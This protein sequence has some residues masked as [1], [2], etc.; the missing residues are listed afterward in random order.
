[1][2]TGDDELSLT[3]YLDSLSNW[4]ANLV[5]KGDLKT[6]SPLLPNLEQ[7]T[8][9][10]DLNLSISG[11]PI[12]PILDGPIKVQEGAISFVVGDQVVGATAIRIDSTFQNGNL[13]ITSIEGQFGQGEIDGSGNITKI[14]NPNERKL[15]GELRFTDASIAPTDN[16]AIYFDAVFEINKQGLEPLSI[17]GETNIT[18]AFYESKTNL[19]KILI[20]FTRFIA[21]IGKPPSVPQRRR[22]QEAIALDILIIAEDSLIVETNVMQGELRGKFRIYDMLAT[23]RVAGSI[24]VIDGVFGFQSSEFD[25]LRGEMLFTD[26]SY[27]IDPILNILGETDVISQSGEEYHVQL[28]VS[29]NMSNP[30]VSF[31]SNS[32]LS[33]RDIVDIL[34]MGSRTQE[35]SLFGFARRTEDRSKRDLLA[36]EPRSTLQDRIFGLTGFSSVD[37]SLRSSVDTGEFIPVVTASRPLLDLFELRIQ[38]ELAGNEVSGASF[39]YSLTPY[40]DLFTGWKTQPKTNPDSSAGNFDVGIKFQRTFPGIRLWPRKTSSRVEE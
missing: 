28:S 35:I 17:S 38:S 3:G 16:T 12:N 8:G 10:L 24:E 26:T 1:L 33:E 25:V 7:I 36:P 14:L 2:L 6:F 32:G 5:G 37:V 30:R 13:L 11:S 29:G 15:S 27:E 4:N 40:L 39:I 9:K 19:R 21:G 34:T 20:A 22:M 18:S 23:P 31:T